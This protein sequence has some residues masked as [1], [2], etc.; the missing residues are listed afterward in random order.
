MAYI[1]GRNGS[2]LDHWRSLPASEQIMILRETL[3]RELRTYRRKTEAMT[4][5]DIYDASQNTAIIEAAGS[6][7]SARAETIL[8]AI[9]GLLVADSILSAILVMW[10]KDQSRNTDS[11]S[12][13]SAILKYTR[14][15]SAEAAQ[16]EAIRWS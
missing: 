15:I 4:K 3:A 1:N 11:W 10:Q 5:P 14:R 12:F 2:N 16:K 13:H 6:I 7:L 8:P 9:P